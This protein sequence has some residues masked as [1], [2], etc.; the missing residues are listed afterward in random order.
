MTK[1]QLTKI[2]KALAIALLSVVLVLALSACGGSNG[3]A[4]GEVSSGQ[5]SLDRI[6]QE[7]KIRIAIPQDTPLFGTQVADGSYEG[8]DVD[9]ANL[10]AEA[11][12]V[13]LELVPVSSAN[14]IPYLTS[15]RVDLVVA[16][17]GVQ[18]AR[19]EV[20]AFSNAYAPF[21]W[22]VFGTED[23]DVDNVEDTIP[24]RVGATLGTM[25]ELAFTEAAPAE[26]EINRF[27]DQATTAQA[28]LSGQVDLIVTGN[29]IAAGLM[30]DNP[31]MGIESKFVIQQSPCHMGALRG[32]T[33][34]IN[35][36]NA[37][38][39]TKKLDGTLDALSVKWFGEPLP[40][41]PE[42]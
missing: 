38:I 8:Y 34:L 28:F 14:R 1:Y 2:Y 36:V 15:G 22:A 24:Y 41:F 7:K 21:F 30:R 6:L 20:I 26:V 12:D 5:Q 29:S 11:M 33:A 18:P 16:N 27:P 13:E 19:A 25:E 9:V 31:G 23:K 39:Y 4:E 42:F 10:I 17:M 3:S 37:F 35:W 32:D 40:V